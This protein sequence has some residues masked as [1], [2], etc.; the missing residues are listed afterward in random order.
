MSKFP[1]MSMQRRLGVE[2]TPENVP[3]T[4][5]IDGAAYRG[6]P[7]FF[8][9]TVTRTQIDANITMYTVHGVHMSG[10]AITATAQIYRDFPVVDWSHRLKT[11]QTTRHPSY[12][13][14]ALRIW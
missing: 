6:I 2:I 3:L 13:T 4:Y 7:K 8:R 1:D 10:V 9:P 14:F 11:P 12:P 5:K